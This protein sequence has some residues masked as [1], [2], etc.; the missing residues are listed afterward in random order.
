MSFTSA[1]SST[2]RAILRGRRLAALLALGAGIAAAPPAAAYP[3]ITIDPSQAVGPVPGSAGTGLSAAFYSIGSHS[4]T[5]AEANAKASAL[6]GP[7]ATFTALTVCFPDCQ[8]TLKDDNTLSTYI[9]TNG[10]NLV[11]NASTLSLALTQYRGFIAIT[12]P[13][14][15]DFGLRGDDGVQLRIGGTTILTIDGIHPFYADK[16][17]VV[18]GAAGLYSFAVDHFEDL[19]DTG[20]AVTLND[21]TTTLP[22]ASLYPAV[23]AVPEPAS[24]ALLG[25]GLLG[26]GLIR[27]RR[28]LR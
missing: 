3:T 1:M 16:A 28:A 14:T 5:L 26:L 6:A 25:A 15:Y 24:T 9:G 27:R 17:F 23:T 11:G 7:T 18:F 4:N 20:V 22:T 2:A 19:G 8:F 10:T 21:Y 13:G 12:T